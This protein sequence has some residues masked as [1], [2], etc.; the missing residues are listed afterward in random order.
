VT[1]SHKLLLLRVSLADLQV[2]DNEEMTEENAMHRIT[3]V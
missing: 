3:L 2:L 1:F